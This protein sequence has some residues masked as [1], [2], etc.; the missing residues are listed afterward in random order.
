MPLRDIRNRDLT[1][2]E[3]D[4][5]KTNSEKHQIYVTRRPSTTS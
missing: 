3:V 2:E 4:Y 5:A 1:F